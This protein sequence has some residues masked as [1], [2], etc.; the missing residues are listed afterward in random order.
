[1]RRLTLPQ[2]CGRGDR[3]SGCT[4]RL[5]SLGPYSAWVVFAV[6]TAMFGLTASVIV[7]VTALLLTTGTPPPTVAPLL[8]G[9]CNGYVALTYD[10]GPSDYTE[11][12]SAELKRNGLH[13]TFFEMGV[14][15]EQN[16]NAVKAVI[17]D[18]N[19]VAN[20]TWDH[21]PLTGLAS[22]TADWQINETSHAIKKAIDASPTLFRPPLGAT[23]P[24]IRH[25]AERHGLTEIIWTLDTKDWEGKTAQQ[26]VNV[27]NSAKA[28]D[29]I[30]M[31]DDANSDVIAV[32][33][34]AAAL[35]SKDLCAGKIVPSTTPVPAWEG[36]SYNAAVV[37]W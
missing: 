29:V 17:A 34:I 12:V 5:P 11:R 22:G 21:P 9:T 10:D 20:H 14:K 4:P 19:V 13:A 32:P 2:P 16:S 24:G 28:G 15:V 30:L 18:G 7:V 37:P 35:A 33:L 25:I 36:L 27:V 26:I 1:M 6:V 8:A 31:H 3:P 23:N